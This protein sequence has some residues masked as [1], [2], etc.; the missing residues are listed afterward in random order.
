M[1]KKERK[2]KG[3]NVLLF[4]STISYCSNLS[5]SK[6]DYELLIEKEWKHKRNKKELLFFYNHYIPFDSLLVIQK[7]SFGIARRKRNIKEI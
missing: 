1:P 3:K 4:L 7:L 2:Y 6:I 5:R